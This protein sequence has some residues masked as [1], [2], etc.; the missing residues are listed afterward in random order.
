[1]EPFTFTAESEA[2]TERLGGALAESLPAGTVVALM[3]T[4][5][6]GKTR[7]VQAFAAACGVPRDAAT[8]PT[9]VLV[10]EYQGRLPIYHIDAY[11]LRDEDEF[12]EL[13]PEEYF[14]SAGVTFVE[15]ADRV[16]DCL[17][18]GRI[19]IQCEATGETSRRFTIRATAPH[20][21]RAVVKARDAML[22]CG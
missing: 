22:G 3:G 15:W 4:L 10:N 5:G 9:F 6:A 19:E 16:A 12:L 17:P 21:E 2:D 1:M 7:L 18:P 20:L 14:D 8:S 13:G 11:R